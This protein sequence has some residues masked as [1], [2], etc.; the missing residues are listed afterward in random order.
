MIWKMECEKPSKTSSVQFSR[1]LVKKTNMEQRTCK[2]KRS[3]CQTFFSP[4]TENK[5][6]VM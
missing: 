4:E 1:H 6:I 5:R 3:W 2:K